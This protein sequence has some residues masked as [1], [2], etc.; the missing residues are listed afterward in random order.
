MTTEQIPSTESHKMWLKAPASLLHR[1]FLLRGLIM[2][3]TSLIATMLLYPAF[4]VS[5]Y[6][7]R[8]D[9]VASVGRRLACASYIS[10]RVPNYRWGLGLLR[11]HCTRGQVWYFRRF[12]CQICRRC[13]HVSHLQKAQKSVSYTWISYTEFSSAFFFICLPCH[14]NVS[15]C[16]LRG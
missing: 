4:V 16:C 6:F 11:L 10:Q 14:G 2:Q 15:G 3:I 1:T 12:L 9:E 13:G 8:G 5:S 7:Q